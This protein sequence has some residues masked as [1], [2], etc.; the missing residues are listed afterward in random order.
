MNNDG[1]KPHGNFGGFVNLQGSAECTD[2][3]EVKSNTCF[4]FYQ[5]RVNPTTKLC[6]Y[7]NKKCDCCRKLYGVHKRQAVKHM[8]EMN[9]VRPISTLENPYPCECCGKLVTTSRTL[10][11]DHCHVTGRFR[12]H[13]CKEC[14]ISTGNLG[15]SVEG[16]MRVIKY[17]NRTE[18]KTKDELKNMIDSF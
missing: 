5:N 8:K 13:T 15:D 12:G 2:C 3:N 11:L 7:V 4:M 6:L 14:N 18:M 16:L 10:Q 1:W 9:I 17:L